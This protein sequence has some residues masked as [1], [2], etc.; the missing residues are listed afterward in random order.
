MW[1]NENIWSKPDS[2]RRIKYWARGF[3]IASLVH[4]CLPD[5][6][7]PGWRAPQILEALGAVLLLWRPSPW[8]FLL[9]ALSTLY[10]LL[11]LRDV[12]TQSMYLTWVAFVAAFGSFGLRLDVLSCV[13]WLTAGTYLLAAFHKLNHDF[14]NPEFSCAHHALRQM[15]AYWS[16]IP[17]PMGL[18]VSLSIAVVVI[19]ILICI[20]L[21]RRSLW[22]WPIGA[23]FHWGL[24]V[25]LAPAFGL[26]MLAGYASALTANHLVLIRATWR[27]HLK[28][29]V[30]LTGALLCLDSVFSGTL[31]SVGQMIKGIMILGSAVVAL[32]VLGTHHAR[33]RR[34]IPSK[35]RI[36]MVFGLLW[37]AHGLLPYFGVK[38]QHSAAMLSNLRIDKPCYNSLIMPTFVGEHDPYVRVL[39]ARIGRGQRPRR[40]QILTDGLW[41]PT[42]MSVMHKNWCIPELRPIL[43][44]GDYRGRAFTISDLCE[45]RWY[46]PLGFTQPPWSG[47][48][49]FQKNLK[50]R[51]ETAC[52][53]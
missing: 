47:L 11:F 46:E 52:I 19:E 2:S 41:T 8:A 45:R 7:Q 9:C 37:L 27:R 30:C 40:E 3:A 29:I 23:V 35:C 16:L 15:D 49:R 33:L 48:Q 13:R 38:Y 28:S 17:F 31:A 39:R 34:R 12:L 18:G 6:E 10:P 5:F 32:F 51:C 36:A 1:G 24:T 42:A 44:E 21:L 14:L 25:T 50:A 22:V 53:H 43:I 26:V 4:L 20:L